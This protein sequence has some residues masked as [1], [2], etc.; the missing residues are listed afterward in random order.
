MANNKCS[1]TFLQPWKNAHENQPW[2]QQRLILLHLQPFQEFPP[3]VSHCQR[4]FFL[5]FILFTVQ[6]VMKRCPCLCDDSVLLIQTP[7][8]ADYHQAGG[9]D[10]NHTA[11]SLLTSTHSNNSTK[12]K[13]ELSDTVTTLF[14]QL[15]SLT[16]I[17][18]QMEVCFM[19]YVSDK[20]QH[21][22]INIEMNNVMPVW[23][24]FIWFPVFTLLD[25]LTWV[26]SAF[27]FSV[28]F[29]LSPNQLPA[30]TWL[31]F[32][33]G[34]GYLSPCLFAC[35]VLC[36]CLWLE[37]LRLKN[38]SEVMQANANHSKEKAMWGFIKP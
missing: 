25:Q 36:V 18:P 19:M 32:A 15:K 17:P 31:W 30:N 24:H 29:V 2:E 1:T 10:R 11:W 4:E 38:K 14:L 28:S 3:V 26:S 12:W 16:D 34:S 7:E 22:L 9:A 13:V 33:D 23:S 6:V 8:A 5:F 37:W 20:Y 21:A 35:A 27:H